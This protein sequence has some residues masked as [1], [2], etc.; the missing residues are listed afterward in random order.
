M[1]N[2]SISLNQQLE[3]E[4]EEFLHNEDMS[5]PHTHMGL[6]KLVNQISAYK[7]E[8]KNLFPEVYITDNL[9]SIRTTLINAEFIKIGTGGRLPGI[10]LRALKK[11]APLAFGGWCIYVL[12]HEDKFEFGL[13]RAGA[14]I[15]SM[16]IFKNIIED[17]NVEETLI[18]V[19]QIAEKIVE[20]KGVK[21]NVLNINFGLSSTMD[22]SIIT[23]QNDFVSQLL[24]NANTNVK[25]Q[26]STF[27]SRLFL[28]VMQNGHGNLSVVVD[29]KKSYPKILTDGIVLEKPIFVD[30]V[31]SEL[32]KMLSAVNTL[33]LNSKLNGAFN[34]IAGMLMSDGIT[35]FSNKGGVLAYNVFIKHPKDVAENLDG[36]ARSRTFAVLENKL[37]TSIKAIYIQSQDGNTESKKHE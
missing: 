11:C 34:I 37:S 36:G 4:L 3:E 9:S 32:N 33:E 8:G 35:V 22:D 16:P 6:T 7:E 12:R 2:K 24:S 23:A 31:I 17:G 15:I 29:S 13:F 30:E 18:A 20:V 26:M 27:Y 21:G 10:I 14:T 19:R 5:C 28:Y 25:E 1:P